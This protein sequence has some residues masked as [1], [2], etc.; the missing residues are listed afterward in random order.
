[1]SEHEPQMPLDP[2]EDDLPDEIA[3]TEGPLTITGWDREI[4]RKGS[5]EPA[6]PAGPA[7]LLLSRA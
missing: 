2:D 7:D 6:R 4:R 1:M 3:Q 5:A